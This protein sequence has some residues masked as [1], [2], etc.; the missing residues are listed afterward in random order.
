MAFTALGSTYLAE[1]QIL[2]LVFHFSFYHLVANGCRPLNFKTLVSRDR[3][4]SVPP[5]LKVFP[6]VSAVI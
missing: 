1:F 6:T 3:A 4:F 2:L 5:N